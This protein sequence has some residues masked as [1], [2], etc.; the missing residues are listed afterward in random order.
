METSKVMRATLVGL[1]KKGKRL[2]E[3]KLDEYRKIQV[4]SGISNNA[5][6]SA[7][8]RLGKTIVYVGVKID[9]GE[10]FR[11]APD[12]GILVVNAELLPLSY[13]GFEPG[14]PGIDAIELA[15]IV[16]RGIRES[17]FIKLKELCI[18]P[19]KKV[20]SVF[21]DIY[22]INYDGNL[23]DASFL[24]SIIALRQAFLPKLEKQGEDW[25]IVYGEKTNKKLPLNSKIP[26]MVTVYK[27]EDVLFLDPNLTEE[28]AC[29][30]KISLGFTE[31]KK[32]LIIHAMQKLGEDK[33]KQAQ[34]QAIIELAKKGAEQIKKFL[35]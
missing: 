14:P 23:V 22:P 5:E 35:I 21:I 31:D 32:E 34:L 28:K 3:R 16:D 12:E 29:D 6:G 18:E 7:E 25:Q 20:Y 11:D 30:A 10:P 19:G 26:L 2:D 13:P 27:M 17:E 33:L 24:A 4:R 15:R 8:V 9:I 1:L